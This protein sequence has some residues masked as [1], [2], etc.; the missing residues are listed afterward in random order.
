MI[1][2]LGRWYTGV[3]FDTEL[4]S[5]HE[6]DGHQ[7]EEETSLAINSPDGNILFFRSTCFLL[8]HSSLGL[9]ET[10]LT[11]THSRTFEVKRNRESLS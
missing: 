8:L 5:Y 1:V 7:L 3:N 4:L 11:R 6:E 9:T 10:M 2:S